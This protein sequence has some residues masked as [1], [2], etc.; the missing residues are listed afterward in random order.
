MPRQDTSFEIFKHGKAQQCKLVTFK[1]ARRGGA[2]LPAH[3]WV[4][5]T[6][7]TGDKLATAARQRYHKN[8]PCRRGKGP[9]KQLFTRCP[10]QRR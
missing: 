5:V 3:R 10:A 6:R 2:V 4:T 8:K 7:C 9:H 1:R